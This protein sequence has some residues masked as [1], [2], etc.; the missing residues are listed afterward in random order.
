MMIIP[1]FFKYMLKTII[2]RKPNK[3][4][5]MNYKFYLNPRS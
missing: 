4:K 1:N 3:I 5:K 2:S